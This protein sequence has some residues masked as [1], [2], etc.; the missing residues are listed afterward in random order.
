MS[1]PICRLVLTPELHRVLRGFSDVEAVALLHCNADPR[2]QQRFIGRVRQLQPVRYGQG[3]KAA[4]VEMHAAEFA[5][6]IARGFAPTPD[7]PEA[8]HQAAVE[9]RHL[10]PEIPVRTLQQPELF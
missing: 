2:L 4:P 8:A 7:A 9:F 3:A 5:P 10:A 6:A 1:D